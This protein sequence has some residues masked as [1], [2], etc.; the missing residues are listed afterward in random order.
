MIMALAVLSSNENSFLHITDWTYYLISCPVCINYEKIQQKTFVN[1]SILVYQKNNSYLSLTKKWS[2][3]KTINQFQKWR[4]LNRKNNQYEKWLLLNPSFISIKQ[5][6]W[7]HFVW[8]SQIV[9]I[10]L[11]ESTIMSLLGIL[12]LKLNYAQFWLLPHVKRM[13]RYRSL[14][15]CY[16]H[17]QST[18]LTLHCLLN[19]N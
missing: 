11:V 1:F 7:L 10:K 9:I 2:L 18:T 4:N 17:M 14:D 13:L 6:Y 8:L 5:V 15:I 12:L 16:D 19:L 3:S